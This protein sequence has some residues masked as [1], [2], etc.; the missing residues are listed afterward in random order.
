M[1]PAARRR[2]IPIQHRNPRHRARSTPP[3]STTLLLASGIPSV[4]TP[5]NDTPAWERLR[6][7]RR[8]HR[9]RLHR[10]GNA[11]LRMPV[12][13]RTQGSRIGVVRVA[14]LA[15]CAPDRHDAA[16]EA[17]TGCP[18]SRSAGRRA[19]ARSDAPKGA[20]D[21]V[22]VSRNCCSIS[23]QPIEAYATFLAARPEK[24]GGGGVVKRGFILATT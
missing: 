9:G 22:P 4:C 5:P 23:G 2:A 10:P 12:G 6:S 8:R 21:S 7:R 15:S 11:A 19:H 20:G 3:A 14:A 17:T 1:G 24:S 18:M 16:V 13:T